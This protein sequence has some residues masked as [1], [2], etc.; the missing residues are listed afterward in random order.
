MG[1]AVIDG[2]RVYF[3]DCEASRTKFSDIN[4]ATNL[5]SVACTHVTCQHQAALRLVLELEATRIA[6][7]VNDAILPM[8]APSVLPRMPL[9]FITVGFISAILLL[10]YFYFDVQMVNVS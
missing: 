1:F 7:Q 3:C 10:H 9:A 2:K 6:D 4:Y 8:N 5:S